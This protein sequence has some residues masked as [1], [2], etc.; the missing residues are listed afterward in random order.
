MHG[1][2]GRNQ[3]GMR[4]TTMDSTSTVRA[5]A[6]QSGNRIWS[7]NIESSQERSGFF[8]GGLS[9]DGSRLYVT[10]G[11][12]QVLALNAKSGQVLWRKGLTAPARN[13]GTVSN[14]RLFVQTT[15]NKV[16]AYS[17]ADGSGLWRHA[18]TA[19]QTGIIGTASPAVWEDTVVS[20][21]SSGEIV[22]LSVI[23]GSVKWTD[24]MAS[25]AGGGLLTELN[26]IRAHPVIDRGQLILVSNAGRTAI[27][28]LARGTQIWQAPIGGSQTPVVSGNQ[29][30]VMG[31]GAKLTALNRDTGTISWQKQ[32]KRSIRKRLSPDVPLA[33][34]GPLLAGNKL[35]VVSAEGE[36]V[37][38]SPATGR[39]VASEKIGGKAV[40][41]P[42]GSAGY[43]LFTTSR[44]RL[45]AYR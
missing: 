9:Y 6:L 18:A 30:F 41:N 40:L 16:T 43:V 3:A 2:S 10:T 28:N 24:T 42:V 33:W 17:V 12:S 4:N 31:T 45:V 44:G 35:I 5:S 34:F 23:D 27:F 26:D 36:M 7:R 38:V 29:V 20:V 32:L 11:F 15:D 14:G 21:F 37:S 39:T 13:A 22:A 19:E 25:L 8:G 1:R